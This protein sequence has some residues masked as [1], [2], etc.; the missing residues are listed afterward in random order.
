MST[1]RNWSA[2]VISAAMAIAVVI[3][4]AQLWVAAIF[5]LAAI[6]Y[7]FPSLQDGLRT[8]GQQTYLKRMA[9]KFDR[10]AQK[11]AEIFASENGIKFKS[12][13]PVTEVNW[14]EISAINFVWQVTCEGLPVSWW[15]IV[16][17]NRKTYSAEASDINT[18]VLLPSLAKYLPGFKIDYAALN[19]EMHSS[20]YPDG[21]TQ[22][23]SKSA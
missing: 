15:E 14:L 7:A 3:Y 8:W 13:N 12:H 4:P 19:S 18:H 11:N 17:I 21:I 2:I 9:K 23:W 1:N 16:T 10:Y 5:L 6:W 20:Q 22:C